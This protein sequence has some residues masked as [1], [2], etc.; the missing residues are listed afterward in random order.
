M[1]LEE[2][3]LSCCSME[4]SSLETPLKILRSIP[5]R[6]TCN[7]LFGHHMNPHYGWWRLGAQV[8]NE[9]LWTTY[10]GALEETRTTQRLIPVAKA[11]CQNSSRLFREDFDNA[12]DW[13]R[14]F[15]G[16]NLRWESLG[17]LFCYWALGTRSLTKDADLRDAEHLRGRD[18]LQMFL[19][20]KLGA[21][22]C[23]EMCKSGSTGNLL[24]ALLLYRY[25]V[26]ESVVTGDLSK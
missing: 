20:Y 18:W 21:S 25:S 15:S 24:L 11:L 1:P 22:M 19:K 9:R 23:L 17:L 6:A 14:S 12:N 4:S 3:N 8:L 2:S 16:P 13:L 10:S 5:D 7:W 26:V